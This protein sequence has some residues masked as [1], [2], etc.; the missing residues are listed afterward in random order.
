MN[1]AIRFLAIAATLVLGLWLA[2]GSHAQGKKSATGEEFF[3]TASIDQSRSQLLLKRPTEVTMLAKVTEKT[4]YADETGKAISFAN[5][6]AG[7]TV[8]VTTSGTGDNLV[9][10]RVRK[11]PMTVENLHRY[12]LDYSEIK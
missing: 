12:Y 8:W 4:A 6:R 3:I 9:A 11:G 7:D 10:T 2:P 5:L 1:K